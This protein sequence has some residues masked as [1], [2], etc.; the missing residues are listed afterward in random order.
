MS[1]FL[2]VAHVSC[3]PDKGNEMRADDATTIG[4][5]QLVNVLKTTD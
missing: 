5:A 2:G 1:K 4:N 3:V